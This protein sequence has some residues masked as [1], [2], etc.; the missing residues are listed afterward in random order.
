MSP[1]QFR[2]F[3]LTRAH[4]IT[5]LSVALMLA[6]FSSAAPQAAPADQCGNAPPPANNLEPPLRAVHA[7]GHSGSNETVIAGWERGGR[8]ER[9]VPPDY[10]QWLKGIHVNWVGIS[11]A[12]TYEDSLDSTVDVSHE[13]FPDDAIRQMVRDFRAEGIS[14]YMTLA[15]EAGDAEESSRPAFRWLLGDPGSPA[16][17]IPDDGE[18][19]IQPEFWPWWPKHPDHE[20]FVAE[21][22][23]TYTQWAVHFA[24]IAEEEGVRLYSLGTET[25]S[26]FRTR[27]GGE[28][29]TNDFGDELQSMVKEV[30]GVYHGLLTYDMHFHAVVQDFFQP[31]SDCLWEDLGLDVVGISAWFD[32]I[33]L[34]PTSVMSV[35]QLEDLYDRIFREHLIPI[36]ERSPGRPILFTEYGALDLVSTPARPGNSE[37]QGTPFVHSDANGNGVDD[38]RETQANVFQALFNTMKRRPEVVQGVFFWDNWMA[39]EELWDEFWGG[40]RSYSI[41]NKPSEAVVRSAYEAMSR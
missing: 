13:T 41:R 8:S 40:V 9:I 37:G 39:D 33:R 22:W 11:V 6:A 3:G 19:A 28:Y 27:S 2:R 20:R 16:T 24:R 4:A 21:F 17:G 18:A 29:W 36:T 7:S 30:R 38:G 14:V 35:S 10:I 5:F 23:E 25:D 34:P 31:G 12:L 26:L 15:F 32:L 1:N